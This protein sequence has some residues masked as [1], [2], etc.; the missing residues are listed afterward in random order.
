MKAWKYI[1]IALSVVM[2][3]LV[4]GW[5]LRNTLIEQI[6]NPLLEEYQL[7]VTDVSLDALATSDANISYLELQHANGTTISIEDLSLPIRTSRTGFRNYSVGKISIGLSTVASDEPPDFAGLLSQLMTLPQRLPQTIISIGEITAPNYPTIRDTHWRLDENEQELMLHV[8]TL[9]LKARLARI[10]DTS[11]LF[12]IS[13]ADAADA[14]SEQSIVAQVQHGDAGVSL[15]GTGTVDLRLL[16]SM[17]GL[18]GIDAATVE[19]GLATL[20]IDGE[21]G[22]DPN[23][24]PI[25]NADITAMT[26]V[27]VNLAGMTD[28]ISSVIVESA[29]TTEISATITDLQWSLRQAQMSLRVLDSHGNDFAVSLKN[30]SCESA[31][32]CSGDISI[33]AGQLTL[34]FADVE[35]FQLSATQEIEIG[36]DSARVLLRPNATLELSGISGPDLEIARLG[37]RLTSAGEF[38]LAGT[39]WQFVAGSLDVGIDDYA[40]YDG[41]AISAP[42]YLDDVSVGQSGGQQSAK[43]GLYTSAST[44]FWNGRRIQLPG[45][46]GE[47]VRDAAE[48]S[49]SFETQGLSAEASVEAS[50]NLD[51]ENGQLSLS[52]A[53][54]SFAS[55]QLSARI[56]PWKTGWDISAG[57]VTIDAQAAWQ[58]VDADWQVTAHT[59][60]RA[61]NLAGAWQETAFT[62]LT[63]SIEAEIDTAAG[64][65]VQPSTI[66]IALVEMGLPIEDIT[67]DYVLHPDALSVDVENLRMS[68][69]QGTVWADPFSFSTASASN[70]LLIHAE[71]IDLAEILSIKEFEAIE[72]SGSIGAELPVTIEGRSLTVSGGTLTGDAPGGVIRYLPGIASGE[73]DVSGIGFATRAL[74]NFEYDSLT[75]VVNYQ[76]DGD[77][78]LQMRLTGRN[79]DLEEGR[80][81]ILNLGVENN[82]PQMLRSLQAARAVEE[83]LERR[84]T[85]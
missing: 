7:T 40:V 19:S 13:F 69:F 55:Q 43:A 26:P 17:I 64:V 85:Q 21:I 60:V 12:G 24:I 11:Y 37:G 14:S 2:V 75:S 72:I 51:N 77:L 39:D 36:E 54:I 74:S 25:V 6:S 22:D 1:A 79:P 41:L 70:N 16:S 81:I 71:S 76:A 38:G 23:Q 62:G 52:D 45:L 4:V 82:V 47:I 10:S 58:R 53:G 73:T 48:V 59:S 83:I 67:A 33:A 32:S 18:F 9:S 61:T 35:R 46:R 50:H 28:A 56:S 20:I 31:P 63:T 5:F 57:T 44:A 65:S 78:V 80:P 29:S 42:L 84:L 8:D 15:H 68:A 30:L 27:R 34:P 3:L 49:V 66:E